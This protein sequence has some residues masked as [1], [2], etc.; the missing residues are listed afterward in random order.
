MA[1]DGV[2]VNVI[3]IAAIQL[4]GLSACAW[5]VEPGFFFI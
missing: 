1:M 3:D 4:N 2:Q 5:R